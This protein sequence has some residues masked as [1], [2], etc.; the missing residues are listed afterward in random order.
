MLNFC[1]EVAHRKAGRVVFQIGL[2]H[3]ALGDGVEKDLGKAAELYNKL[4]TKGHPFAQVSR[5][6]ST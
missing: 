6:I 1:I 5:D 2:V 3:R 4:A